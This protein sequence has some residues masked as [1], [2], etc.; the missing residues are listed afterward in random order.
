MGMLVNSFRKNF[1]RKNK[2]SLCYFKMVGT[3]DVKLSKI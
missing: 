3:I 2:C 1:T